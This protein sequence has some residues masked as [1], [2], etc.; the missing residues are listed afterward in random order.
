MKNGQLMLIVGAVLL[1]GGC[2]IYASAVDAEN[3]LTKY[4]NSFGREDFRSARGRPG[5]KLAGV[6]AVIAGVAVGYQGL[7]V[8]KKESDE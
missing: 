3:T 8:L 7:K 1:L 6:V 4:I 5:A 2:F